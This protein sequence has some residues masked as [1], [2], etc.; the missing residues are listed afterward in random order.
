LHITKAQKF[1][2]ANYGTVKLHNC[3]VEDTYAGIGY[4]CISIHYTSGIEINGCELYGNPEKARIDAID[5]DDV[6]SAVIMNNKIMDFEDDGVDFGTGAK[7]VVVKNN[8]ISN[9]NFGVSVGEKSTATVSRNVIIKCDAGFQS[10]TGSTITAFNNTLYNNVKGFELHHGGS[11]GSY[12]A[13]TINSSIV[14]QTTGALYTVQE[15]SVLKATYSISDTDTLPGET[16][17][18]GDPMFV[19]ADS[20]NFLLM[21]NSPC[22]DAG[23]PSLPTDSIGNVIDI[24]AFEYGDTNTVSIDT[25]TDPTDTITF[26][27]GNS[28]NQLVIWPNSVSSKINILNIPDDSYTFQ[29]F[30]MEGRT[31]ISGIINGHKE[32]IYVNSMENGIYFLR[33]K[34]R[35]TDRYYQTKFIYIH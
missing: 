12:G 14:S 6:D 34:N 19:R 10:H 23:D 8:F 18:F 9:C 2:N 29:V 4:D 30:N 15:G 5:I 17:L 16:N 11:S 7:G 25:T 33:L 13:L 31:I 26:I 35:R 21:K 22:I 20:L 27:I 28:P 3:I 32:R 1:L 24:G